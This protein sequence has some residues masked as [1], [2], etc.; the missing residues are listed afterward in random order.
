[1]LT[2]GAGEVLGVAT[3]S[4]LLGVGVAGEVMVDGVDLAAAALDAVEE[5][6]GGKPRKVYNAHSRNLIKFGM[7]Q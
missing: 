3:D 2:S 1:M 7:S 5:A 6:G 4:G